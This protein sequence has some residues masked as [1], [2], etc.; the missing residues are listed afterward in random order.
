MIYRFTLV[1]EEEEDFSREIKINSDATFFDFHKAIIESVG[2]SD[3][4]ITSFFTCEHSWEKIT[5]IT[6]EDMGLSSSDEDV[7]VMRDTRIEEFVEDEGQ[8]LLYRFDPM[9]DR[10]FFIELAEITSGS[11]AKAECTSKHG[12]APKQ[13]G[14]MDFDTT[15][16]STFDS[17][18]EFFG[19]EE[20]N[21]DDLDLEGLG[22]SEGDPFEN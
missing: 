15:I 7:Y 16:A 21:D 8:R 11:L 12:Q 1:S 14:D 18:E 17:G 4:Q 10:Y 13:I 3:D 20:F 22:I 6:I 9:N 2:Y 5:E 19:S